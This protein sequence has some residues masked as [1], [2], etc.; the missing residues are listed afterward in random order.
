MVLTNANLELLE[1][2]ELI[3]QVNALK[4][5]NVNLQRA[6]NEVN[7]KNTKLELRVK[8]LEENSKSTYEK[9]NE[10]QKVVAKLANRSYKFALVGFLTVIE[11]LL[12]RG[13]QSENLKLDY[14]QALKQYF[15]S[16]VHD[17]ASNK[18]KPDVE[19]MLDWMDATL[20]NHQTLMIKVSLRSINSTNQR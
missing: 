16:F 1:K 12:A 3:L 18:I 20:D 8:Q 2:C 11:Q 4:T 13:Y 10:I 14:L 9:Y 7:S 5:L 15:S 19:E 17:K 6:I